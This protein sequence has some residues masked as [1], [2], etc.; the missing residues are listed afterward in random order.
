MPSAPPYN[1]VNYWLKHYGLADVPDQRA[2]SD[3]AECEPDQKIA[4]L[5]QQLHSISQGKYDERVFDATVGAKR[6]TKHGSYQQWAKLMLLWLAE[7][8]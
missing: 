2:I 7:H 4:A 6:K 3:F 8:K 1:E 5:K